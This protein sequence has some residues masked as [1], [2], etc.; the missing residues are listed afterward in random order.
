MHMGHACNCSMHMPFGIIWP[1]PSNPSA[2]NSISICICNR[3]T[4]LA[5]LDL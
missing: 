2:Q 4:A 1:A 3:H 5:L